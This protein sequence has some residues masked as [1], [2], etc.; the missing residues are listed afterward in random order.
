[1]NRP[2]VLG[3]VQVLAV[4]FGGGTFRASRTTQGSGQHV[5]GGGHLPGGM[6]GIGGFAHHQ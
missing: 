3:P 4:G 2:A 5:V 6:L 1:M